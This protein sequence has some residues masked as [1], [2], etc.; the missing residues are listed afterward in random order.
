MT[1]AQR[2]RVRPVNDE[3]HSTPHAAGPRDNVNKQANTSGKSVL[4]QAWGSCRV[5]RQVVAAWKF[6]AN[7]LR[8]KNV[9][10]A[11]WVTRYEL[12]PYSH[13]SAE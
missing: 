11:L 13:G 8:L 2:H 1:T 9:G 10:L 4:Q 6:S 12:A 5:V 7:L 3:A